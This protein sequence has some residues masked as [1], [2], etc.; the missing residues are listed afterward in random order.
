MPAPVAVQWATKETSGCCMSRAVHRLPC[1]RPLIHAQ[2]RKSNCNTR[3]TLRYPAVYEWQEVFFPQRAHD[4]GI[5]RRAVSKCALQAPLSFRM[6]GA[7]SDAM[8]TANAR[9]QEPRDRT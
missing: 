8:P 3:H 2:M 7:R 6:N 9:P 1:V 5:I 4:T